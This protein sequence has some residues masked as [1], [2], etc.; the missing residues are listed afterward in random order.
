MSGAGQS[1]HF[2]GRAVCPRYRD[3]ATIAHTPLR[4]LRSEPVLEARL[5]GVR[6]ASDNGSGG[7][8]SQ[9]AVQGQLRLN[10]LQ[11]KRA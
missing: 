4:T 3:I 7:G 2:A 1:R 11:Q 9:R 10:T 6:L 5:N 8:Y